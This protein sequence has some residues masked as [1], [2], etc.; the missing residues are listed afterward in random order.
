MKAV[1]KASLAVAIF[2]AAAI[3]AS[4]TT[5]GFKC[6]TNNS[7]AC[8]TFEGD[9]TA[10]ITVSGNQL[11]V[12]FKNAPAGTGIITLANADQDDA[13]S[14]LITALSSFTNGA[15]VLWEINTSQDLPA[16]NSATPPF[17]DD[18]N[19]SRVNAGGVDNG[20]NGGEQ[21][22]LIYT[23]AAGVDQAAIDAALESGALRF[24]IHAQ[25]LGAG[26]QSES[27]INEPPDDELVPEPASLLLLGL[28]LLSVA[29]LRARRD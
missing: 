28:G 22:T 2:L 4:A 8:S 15:G 19:S 26:G 9:F 11:S 3:P 27:L 18:F 14:A 10:E 1:L 7:G 17:E 25:S 24:G 13:N 23:L 12:V 6:I 21:V 29:G 5:V 20:V 16:G